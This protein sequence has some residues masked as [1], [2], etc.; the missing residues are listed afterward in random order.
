MF[1]NSS[2]W[3][4]MVQNEKTCSKRF[5][6]FYRNS[7]M[8]LIILITILR[9]VMILDFFKCIPKDSTF[10]HDYQENEVLDKGLIVYLIP[11]MLKQIS[12]NA[13]R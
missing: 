12:T 10:N 11:K 4:S 6:S 5:H 8:N 13:L 3:L 2:N 9:H 1:I 7:A